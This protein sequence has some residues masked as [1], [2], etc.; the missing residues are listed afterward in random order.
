MT[1]SR[2][3]LLLAPVFGGW[4]L[5]RFS[6]RSVFVTQAA[7]ASVAWIGVGRMPETLATPSS[8]S[9]LQTAA[10]Y[11]DLL[12]NRRYV[13]HALLMSLIVLPHFAFIGGS[14]HIYITGMGLS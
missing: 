11:L 2:I 13:G 8:T 1:N 9:A 14:A 6:W 7:I 5:T 3:L 12:H 4:I 10:I